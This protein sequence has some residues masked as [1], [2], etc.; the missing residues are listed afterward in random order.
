[1]SE[2]KLGRLVF[3]EIE[4]LKSDSVGRLLREIDG[5]LMLEV[6]LEM[7]VLID[8]DVLESDTDSDKDGSP[9]RLVGADMLGIDKLGTPV[10]IEG[11]LGR[12]RLGKLVV[13]DMV[14]VVSG[15][16]LGGLRLGKPVR[17]ESDGVLRV[18]TLG[19]SGIDGIGGDG[20]PMAHGIP[21]GPTVQLP[22]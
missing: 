5:T 8:I 4:V 20:R 21:D 2:L 7:P 18:G 12:M 17:S 3:N 11:T 13:S 16:R 6:K 14:G 1:M 19:T 15:G 10:L 22:V 9:V